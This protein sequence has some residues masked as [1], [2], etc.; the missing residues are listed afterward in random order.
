[1]GPPSWGILALAQGGSELVSWA[2]LPSLVPSG[3]HVSDKRQNVQSVHGTHAQLQVQPP[4][5]LGPR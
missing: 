5:G 2:P 4:Q 1:M 3:G